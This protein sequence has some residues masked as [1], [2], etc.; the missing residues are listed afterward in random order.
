MWLAAIQ[1][2]F[3]I[4]KKMRLW[5]EKQYIQ[6]QRVHTLVLDKLNLRSTGFHCP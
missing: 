3:K 1:S 4:K 6:W 2:A 5:P